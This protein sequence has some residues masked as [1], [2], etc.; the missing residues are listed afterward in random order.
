M[1]EEHASTGMG[2]QQH[3]TELKIVLC[4][5]SID[6]FQPEYYKIDLIRV[7]YNNITSMC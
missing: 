4:L 7:P 1:M 3:N 6:H 2:F 5:L